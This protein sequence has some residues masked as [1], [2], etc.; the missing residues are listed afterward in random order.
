[1]S[2]RIGITQRVEVIAD[3]DERRDCLDQQWFVLLEQLGLTPTPIPN[4]LKDVAQWLNA[5]ALDGFILS[6][7][8]DL[9]HLPNSSCSA[10]ERDITETTILAHAHE[11]R[12]PVLGVCRGLQMMNTW[13]GGDLVP[14]KGHVATRHPVNAVAGCTLFS[15]YTE[16]NSFHDWAIMETGLAEELQACLQSEDGTIEAARHRTQ[17]WLAIMW[18]PE[19][20]TPFTQAD[21][22]LITQLFKGNA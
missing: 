3:Y 11:Q 15:P 8:N 10:P 6:G 5:M 9:T 7:G 16:V 13:L 19:R 1:M 4:G 12:L 22:T 20:E 17:T 2:L 14:V 21:I 18:H